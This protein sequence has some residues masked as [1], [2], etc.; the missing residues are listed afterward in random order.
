MS[1]TPL[2]RS[3]VGRSHC[4]VV[5]R[6]CMICFDFFETK[7]RGPVAR[8]CSRAC[9]DVL[10]RMPAGGMIIEGLAARRD[11]IDRQIEVLKRHSARFTSLLRLHGGDVACFRGAA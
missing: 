1:V 9:R 8:T 2:F 3:E 5:Q 7:P 10:G 4:A 11:A 6:R